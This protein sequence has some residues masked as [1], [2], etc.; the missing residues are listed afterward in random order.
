MAPDP[1]QAAR[2]RLEAWRL[3]DR[4]R[5]TYEISE[6]HQPTPPPVWRAKLHEYSRWTSGCGRTLPEAVEAVFRI[7]DR[8]RGLREREARRR[9]AQ[10]V[11]DGS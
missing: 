11:A 3:A 4:G 5:R 2:E 9:P 7:W 1:D 8:E 10:E 6:L